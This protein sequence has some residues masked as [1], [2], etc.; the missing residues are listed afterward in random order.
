[1]MMQMLRAGGVPLLVDDVRKADEDNPRGY[2]ELEAVKR[3]RR[4]LLWLEG[5]PGKAVKVIHA[6]L[7]DLPVDQAYRVIFMQ[8]NI[9]EVVQSQEAMLART[10]REGASLSRE[11]LAGALQ[12]QVDQAL[13]HLQSHDC[14]AVRPTS[15]EQVITEP[16]GQAKAI[17]RFLGRSLNVQA[18]AAAVQPT[19]YRQQQRDG[20]T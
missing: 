4:D 2:F 1:M 16:L 10:G 3:T 7:A 18:M 8:R 12:R 14:F 11:R 13:A 15:Y 6:L 19:L 20:A 5:A 17:C 9:D